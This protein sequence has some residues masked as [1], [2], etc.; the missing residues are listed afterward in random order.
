MNLTASRVPAFRERLGG[1]RLPEAQQESDDRP[2][3]Q[4]IGDK[5]GEHGERAQ[6]A[7]QAKRRKVREDERR[8]T[9]RPCEMR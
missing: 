1:Q 8:E 6:P 2:Q 3:D 5:R 9:L 7:K 4:E